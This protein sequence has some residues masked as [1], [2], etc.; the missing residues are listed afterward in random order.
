MTEGEK[1]LRKLAG[2]DMVAEH[3]GWGTVQRPAGRVSMAR[4]ERREPGQRGSRS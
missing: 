4:R 2:E 1:V 3:V